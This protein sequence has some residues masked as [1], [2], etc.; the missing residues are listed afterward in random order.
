MP[1]TGHTAFL[2]AQKEGINA[3]KANTIQ[4]GVQIAKERT[5]QNGIVILSPGAPSY[6]QYKNFEERGLDFKKNIFDE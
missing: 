4:E 1:D 3:I 5:L 6:N 2:L